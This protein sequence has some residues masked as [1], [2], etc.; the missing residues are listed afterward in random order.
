VVVVVV[1]VV[2]GLL[3]S[4]VRRDVRY[5]DPDDVFDVD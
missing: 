5:C 2:V 1:V 3:G 4:A